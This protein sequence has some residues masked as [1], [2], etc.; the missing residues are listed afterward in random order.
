MAKN[1]GCEDLPKGRL[2]LLAVAFFKTGIAGACLSSSGLTGGAQLER[3]VGERGKE[4]SQ[5]LLDS[6]WPVNACE[7]TISCITDDG[8]KAREMIKKFGG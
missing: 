2:L 4:V 1:V 8:I 5:C 6:N 3:R 7:C